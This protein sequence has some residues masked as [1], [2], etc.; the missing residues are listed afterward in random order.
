MP[1]RPAA[2]SADQVDISALSRMGIQTR[3]E[4]QIQGRE[5]AESHTVF[6][7]SCGVVCGTMHRMGPRV[8]VFAGINIIGAVQAACL[9]V[10]LL[11]WRRHNPQANRLLGALAL[12]LAVF[13]MG[14]VLKTTR[15]YLVW[16]HLTLIHDPGLF[17]I[18]PLMYL[19]V[20]TLRTRGGL[21]RRDALHFVPAVA[22]AVYLAPYFVQSGPAKLAYLRSAGNTWYYIK[23]VLL[24]LQGT[25][26]LVAMVRA[27]M[28]RI[29]GA[30]ALW[31]AGIRNATAQWKFVAGLLACVLVLGALRLFDFFGVPRHFYIESNLVMP[32]VASLTVYWMAYLALTRPE[33]V[34]FVMAP[35]RSERI[36]L[37]PDQIEKHV[38]RL[39]ALMEQEKPFRDGDLTVKT[40]AEKLGLPTAQL[41]A[42][43]NERLA[44]NFVDFVN[45]YR[46]EEAKRLLLDGSKR[47]Y[48]V[49]AIGDE[50]GFNSKSAFNAAFRKYTGSTPSDFRKVADS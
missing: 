5:D 36:G 22:C 12:V 26:Y 18:A 47:H 43:I 24:L 30:R 50:V 32:F 25:A 38:A 45:R 14:A 41:S 15:Y 6:L 8:S 40:L 44:E 9:G 21:R 29:G 23:S 48:S 20:K 27:V 46:I 33:M 1:R 17:A 19:Y 11:T 28:P 34:S 49:L 4:L 7:C 3:L 42:L 35:A 31:Q 13:I 16:P 10:V 2:D 39:L 37:R